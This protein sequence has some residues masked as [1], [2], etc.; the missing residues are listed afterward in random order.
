MRATTL[1]FSTTSPDTTCKLSPSASHPILADEC[2]DDITSTLW[3]MI[4]ENVAIICACLPMCRM[5]LALIFPKTFSNASS[6][7]AGD[8]SGPTYTFGQGRSSQSQNSD[9][10]PY[11]GPPQTGGLNRSVVQHSDDTSEEFILTS[12]PS[13]GPRDDMDHSIRKTTQYEISYERDPHRRA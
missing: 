6:A 10:K 9:W 4:E 7:A 1:N 12:V 8:S 2:L 11:S 3:T 13:V 5:V